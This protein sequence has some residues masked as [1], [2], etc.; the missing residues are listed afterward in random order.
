M[1]L[2]LLILL[3]LLLLLLLMPMCNQ[4]GDQISACIGL[5]RSCCHGSTGCQLPSLS[6]SWLGHASYQLGSFILPKSTVS[7][8]MAQINDKTRLSWTGSCVLSAGVLHPARKHSVKM[9][10]MHR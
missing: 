2:L 9:H 3:L 7:K 1:I 4:R 5:S 6:R 10:G 8:R